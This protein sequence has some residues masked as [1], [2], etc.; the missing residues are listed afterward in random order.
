MLRRRHHAGTGGVSRT[1]RPRRR[2]TRNPVSA[3]G[4]H[5]RRSPYTGGAAASALTPHTSDKRFTFPFPRQG[6]SR[7]G[8]RPTAAPSHSPNRPDPHSPERRPGRPPRHASARS[9]PVSARRERR[10]RAAIAVGASVAATR[11]LG[12]LI[13][14]LFLTVS[15]GVADER[16]LDWR[17]AASHTLIAL[18][19]AT[20]L[21]SALR[22]LRPRHAMHQPARHAHFGP[23]GAGT[24]AR[25]RSELHRQTHSDRQVRYSVCTEQPDAVPYRQK[26][27]LT[28]GAGRTFPVGVRHLLNLS[29]PRGPRHSNDPSGPMRSTGPEGIALCLVEEEL[30]VAAAVGV[31]LAVHRSAGAGGGGDPAAGDQA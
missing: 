25:T 5:S 20:L 17:G 29:A 19:G 24:D 16:L 23:Q 7:G 11:T 2:R 3:L 13:T 1:R 6:I 27:A 18:L 14:D 12:V 9:P 15:A 28:V 21:A 26:P 4:R 31:V 8:C 10:V 22:T 30:L